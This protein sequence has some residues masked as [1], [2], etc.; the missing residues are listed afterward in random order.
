MPAL[1]SAISWLLFTLLIELSICTMRPWAQLENYRTFSVANSFLRSGDL[2]SFIAL[3]ANGQPIYRLASQ[4]REALRILQQHTAANCLAIPI[5]NGRGERI[6]WYAPFSGQVCSW[7]MADETARVNALEKLAKLQST[8]AALSAR[9][10][11]TGKASQQ[12][13]A[14]LLTQV[15]RFPDQNAIYLVDGNPVITFWGFIKSEHSLLREPLDDLFKTA[16]VTDKNDITPTIVS[17]SSDI[18]DKKMSLRWWHLSKVTRVLTVAV[19]ITLACF[20]LFNPF[21]TKPVTKVEH[22]RVTH[23]RSLPPSF[24]LVGMKLPLEQAEILPPVITLPPPITAPQPAPVDTQVL[25]LPSKSVK[26]GSTDFLDGKWHALLVNDDPQPSLPMTLQ[27]Q[28]KGGQGTVNARQG[29][30]MTCRAKVSAG[31]MPSGNLIINSRIKARCNDGSYIQLPVLVCKQAEKQR[32]NCLARYSTDR[33][34]P[35]TMTRGSK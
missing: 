1:T 33:H 15:M 12:R 5:E 13:F 11:D 10:H 9:A 35:I 25:M 14:L 34:F 32:A 19:S 17:I 23:P 21:K 29:D 31:F 30:K 16:T 28:F 4:L 24:S 6:D 3:S 2:E 26:I 27:Y 7:Q 18:K 22:A 8:F 20:F